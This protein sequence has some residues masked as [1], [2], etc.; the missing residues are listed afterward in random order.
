M[1]VAADSIDAETRLAVE[2]ATELA[3]LSG[4][5]DEPPV[6]AVR[7]VLVG[8]RY[9]RAAEATDAEIASTTTLFAPVTALLRRLRFVDLPAAVAG[10]NEALAGLDVQPSV[11]AHD[12]SPLH[13]HWTD[14]DAAVGEQVVADM[15]LALAHTLCDSGLDRF[16]VCDADDCG[17]IYFDTTRNRSRRFCSDPRCASRT[18]TAEHRARLRD[19]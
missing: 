7:D 14:R 16:G 5:A 13:L 4:G 18:H 2:A 15:L 11:Q 3:N 8:Y 10:V 1:Y 12:G 6:A 17:R 9:P 19:E